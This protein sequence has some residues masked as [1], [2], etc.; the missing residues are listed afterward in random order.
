[1]TVQAYRIDVLQF[2]RYLAETDYTVTS[3]SQVQRSHITEYVSYLKGLGRTGVTRARKLISLQVF[4]SFLVKSGLIPHSPATGIDRPK[5]EKRPK[6]F[7]RPDEYNKLLVQAA[8]NPRDYAMLQVFLQ[9]AS[10]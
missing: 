2:I 7:L 6:D 4:F 8:G 5:K 3:A 1:M 9:P 10:E